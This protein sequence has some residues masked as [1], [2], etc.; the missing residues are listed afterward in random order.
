M[1]TRT[2]G[3]TLL[4][5]VFFVVGLAG[6]AA[7]WA[8]WPRTSTTSPLFAVFALT[9]GCTSLA[10]A[11]LTWRRSRF[12]GPVFAAAIG[13]LLFPARFIVPTGQ[14]FVP[15]LVVL[16]LVAFFGHR[17]LRRTYEAGA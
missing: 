7:S 2:F 11:V 13:L 3:T 8:A 6:I 16:T 10:T 14:L 4:A 17:Y 9:W 1:F 5:C 12:A 15:S